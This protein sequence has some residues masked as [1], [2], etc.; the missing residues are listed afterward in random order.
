MSNFFDVSKMSAIQAQYEAQKI[1][2]AP[3][4]FQAV[5]VLRESGILKLLHEQR[6]GTVSYTH[7]RAHET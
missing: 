3:I 6:A 4:V 5:R 1:A 7:L 2:F